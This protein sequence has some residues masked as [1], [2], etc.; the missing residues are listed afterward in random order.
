ME[1]LPFFLLKLVA[2]IVFYI[3]VTQIPLNHVLWI[4]FP[5]FGAYLC[6]YTWLTDRK[7][8]K[9][10]DRL[11]LDVLVVFLAATGIIFAFIG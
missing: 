1:E 10:E 4:L 8:L 6:F 11:V 5:F 9:V 7:K 3:L 2:S